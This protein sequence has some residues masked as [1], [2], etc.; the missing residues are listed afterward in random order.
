[1]AKVMSP[2]HSTEAR[3]RV[4]GL[5]FNTWRGISTVKS[6]S[7]PAQPRSTTQLAVRS[8]VTY[9]T[10]KWALLDDTERLHW[11]EYAALHT[12]IDWTG[13]PKRLS[14]LN[15]Y[16]RCNT[17][18]SQCGGT[19]IDEPPAVAAPDPIVSFQAMDQALSIRLMWQAAAGT[20]LTADFWVL[21]P[22]STGVA[23]KIE[24][25]KRGLLTAAQT[26]DISIAN[27]S[28]GHYT[29]WARIISEVTGL[30]STWL[31]DTCDVSAT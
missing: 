30:A 22:H 29:V 2:L 14:G 8:L 21:G 5:V 27:K 12:E 10:R 25:A 17:R 28:V 9:L 19:L 7:S 16:V 11:N 18:I 3:G 31:S 6:N 24:R 15:W 4:G 23:A 20:D 1:M 13:N 26:P